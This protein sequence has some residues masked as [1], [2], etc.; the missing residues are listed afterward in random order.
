[1]S[2]LT[3][4]LFGFGIMLALMIARMP[5]AVAMAIVG[6]GGIAWLS[7]LPVAVSAVRLGPF[8]R[9][10]SYSLGMIPLF[11]LMAFA[12]ARGQMGQGLFRV[13]NLWLGH[14]RGGLAMATVGSCAGFSAICGSSIA[15]AGA[16]T[17][18][19]YPEMV[20]ARYHPSMSAGVIAA[21]ATLG[22]MI[23]PSVILVL[24]GI[25][26]EQSIGRLLMAGIVPGIIESLLFLVAIAAI[27]RFAPELAPRAANAVAWRD[28]LR[29]LGA[30]WDIGLLFGIVVGGIYFGIV[31]PMES[32]SL[33][34][35]A[36]VLFGLLRR[37]L[38]GAELREAL[39]QSATLS[40]MIFLIVIGADLFGTFIALSQL[41]T[42][43]ALAI[44]DLNVPPFVV[45]WLI[46]GVYIVLGALMD[47]LSMIL[48]TIPVFFPLITSLGYDP[49]WF[50]IIVVIVAQIGMIT[51]PL[52]INVFIV[53]GIVKTVPVPAVFRG[54]L[55]FLVAQIMLA[56]LLTLWPSIALFLPN[57][58]F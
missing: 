37:T 21:G 7:S 49:V 39:I 4:G 30:L 45:L 52:G 6:F 8:D 13:A 46:I 41:P 18:I 42:R 40:A 53:A 34:A 17:S 47:E 32:A 57:R 38:P 5:I 29:G 3:V 2:D 44:A 16:M 27:V 43:L 56:L 51:P 48:L 36:A 19:A 22:I 55:P 54:V 25:I 50:G 24:Y 9:A 14:L 28:R 15:T 20:R 23:P 31:T 10:S 11:L 1:M 26:T 58:M 33:G 35:A 12:A